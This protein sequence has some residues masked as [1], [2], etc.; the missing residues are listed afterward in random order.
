MLGK[1]LIYQR[2]LLESFLTSSLK[3]I[4]FFKLTNLVLVQV[5][6]FLECLDIFR[7]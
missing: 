6:N 2:K 3:D 1:C 7:L 5:W 4:Q